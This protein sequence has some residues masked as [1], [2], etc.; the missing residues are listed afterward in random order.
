MKKEQENDAKAPK[1]MLEYLTLRRK[2]FEKTVENVSF[3]H[4]KEYDKDLRE[5]DE[6]KSVNKNRYFK[7]NYK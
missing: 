1:D 3:G 5:I 6:R 7:Q 4:R 2:N